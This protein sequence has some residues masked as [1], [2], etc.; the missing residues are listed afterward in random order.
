MTS[1]EIEEFIT[2]LD[3]ESQNMCVYPDKCTFDC[4]DCYLCRCDYFNHIREELK[5]EKGGSYE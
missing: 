2:Y 4:C 3:N 5:R 1:E